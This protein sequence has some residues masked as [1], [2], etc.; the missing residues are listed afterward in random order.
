MFEIIRCF[1]NNYHSDNYEALNKK[2]ED[3][4]PGKIQSWLVKYRVENID[5]EK[6]IELMV[7]EISAI[8]LQAL[9]VSD[10]NQIGPVFHGVASKTE[11]YKK[12]LI[13]RLRQKTDTGLWLDKVY[14]AIPLKP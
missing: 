5:T 13:E 9:T 7:E 2:D 11:T 4:F 8:P 14:A 12:I 6:K 3:Y 1:F 10:V